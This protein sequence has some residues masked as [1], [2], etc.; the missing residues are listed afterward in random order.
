MKT[1]FRLGCKRWGAIYTLIPCWGLADPYLERLFVWIKVPSL[2]H[3]IT[4][5]AISFLPFVC[6]KTHRR[7]IC[8]FSAFHF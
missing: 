7:T 5:L 8:I 1:F 3:T 2:F 4:W 6:Q